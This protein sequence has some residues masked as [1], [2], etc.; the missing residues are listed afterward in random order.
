M[1]ATC[2]Q[3]RQ[4]KGRKGKKGEGRG[5]KKRKEKVKHCHTTTHRHPNIQTS[6]HC[7]PFNTVPVLTNA[8]KMLHPINT[9]ST[10]L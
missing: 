6:K 1:M 2:R 8:K 3:E 5:G 4:G 10:V 7:P 9:I